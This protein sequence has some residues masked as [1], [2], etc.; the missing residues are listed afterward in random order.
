VT[1]DRPKELPDVEYVAETSAD[2]ENWT[3]VPLTVTVDGPVQK[4]R[5]FAAAGPTNRRFIQ[6]RF[7]RK[8]APVGP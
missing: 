1:F 5:A 6:V 4:V 3:A 2:L 8:P 7:V